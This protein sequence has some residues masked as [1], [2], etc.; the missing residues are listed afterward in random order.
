MARRWLDGWQSGWRRGLSEWPPVAGRRH[1][2]G[3]LHLN[4]NASQ[5]D[6][7]GGRCKAETRSAAA[8]RTAYGAMVL[9]QVGAAFRLVPPSR[10]FTA[11][12]RRSSR[13]AT[14][15]VRES[16]FSLLHPAL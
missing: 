5:Y 9:G 7:A 10:I 14:R 6:I 8:R 3:S 15:S 1:R 16:L 11:R 4:T 13:A 12:R 2:C